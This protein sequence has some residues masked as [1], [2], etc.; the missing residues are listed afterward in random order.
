MEMK[1]YLSPEISVTEFDQTTNILTTS[2]LQEDFS[3]LDAEELGLK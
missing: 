1:K 3:E 2:S